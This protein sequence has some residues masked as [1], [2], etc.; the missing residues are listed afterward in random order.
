MALVAAYRT[1]T[2][3]KTYIPEHWIGHPRLGVGYAPT[4]RQKA[5][6]RATGTTRPTPA[7]TAKKER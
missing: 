2:G 5:A 3:E 1:D 6:D 4:P 7:A